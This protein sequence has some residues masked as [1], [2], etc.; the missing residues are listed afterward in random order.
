MHVYDR[1]LRRLRPRQISRA[2]HLRRTAVLAAAMAGLWLLATMC[3]ALQAW[4]GEGSGYS[5]SLLVWVILPLLG[6]ILFDRL[7]AGLDRSCGGGER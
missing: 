6:L 1:I 5:G 4:A 2:A 3:F 7:Q